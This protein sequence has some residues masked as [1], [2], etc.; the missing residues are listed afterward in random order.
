MT[1]VL[2]SMHWDG[3]GVGRTTGQGRTAAAHTT[4]IPRT[5]E[6]GHHPLIHSYSFTFTQQ[7]INDDQ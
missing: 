2:G 7:M 6:D 5:G 4:A 3:Q 1:A